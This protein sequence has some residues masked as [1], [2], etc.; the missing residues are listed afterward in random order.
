[1]APSD[2]VPV[3]EPQAGGSYTRDPVT[4]ELTRTASTAEA[5][6]R[7]AKDQA[8]AAAPPAPTAQESAAAAAP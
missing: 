1:M 6:V 5:Q 8:E 2:P 7:A 3:P 4:G